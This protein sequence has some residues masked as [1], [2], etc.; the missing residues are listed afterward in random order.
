MTKLG[1]DHEFGL[2]TVAN[3]DHGRDDGLGWGNRR[4]PEL[5]RCVINNLRHVDFPKHLMASQ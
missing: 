5:L 4:T 2:T 3:L 1:S